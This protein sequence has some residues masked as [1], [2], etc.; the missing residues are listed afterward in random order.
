M[1]TMSHAVSLLY[2]AR[3]DQ[4]SFLVA[5][6]TCPCTFA[7]SVDLLLVMAFQQYATLASEWTS[8]APCV[9]VGASAMPITQLLVWGCCVVGHALRR[10]RLMG[11]AKVPKLGRTLRPR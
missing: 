6:T 3:V 7:R 1:D 9:D 11:Q 4:S 8:E 10:V 2:R 5:N